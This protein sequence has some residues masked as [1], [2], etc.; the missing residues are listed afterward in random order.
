[1]NFSTVWHG[2]IIMESTTDTHNNICMY[3]YLQKKLKFFSVCFNCGKLT[4]EKYFLMTATMCCSSDLYKFILFL[5]SL[6][7]LSSIHMSMYTHT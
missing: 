7:Y 1:M 2:Q 5:Q 6:A 4:L 3:F